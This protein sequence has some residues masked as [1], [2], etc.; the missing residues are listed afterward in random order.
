[1]SPTDVMYLVKNNP[2]K[3]KL[4]VRG[5][6]EARKVTERPAADEAS[7]STKL[8]TVQVDDDDDAAPWSGAAPELDEAPQQVVAALPASAPQPGSAVAAEKIAR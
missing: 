5:R 7:S 3:V 8:A 6:F 2:S 1:M 4:A